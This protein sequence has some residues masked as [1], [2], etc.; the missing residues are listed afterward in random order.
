[1]TT[2]ETPP[3]D[4]GGQG[5]GK[6]K[7]F[8][9]RDVE[10]SIL[11]ESIQFIGR[12]GKLITENLIDYTRKN[13][14]GEFPDLKI[15]LQTWNQAKKKQV[16]IEELEAVGVFFETLREFY[17]FDENID[18]FVNFKCCL[19]SKNFNKATTC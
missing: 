1:M 2:Q 16:I 19:Q 5:E 14:L 17:K 6:K 11:N 18:D 8:Y 15:F 4:T 9:V 10:V 3:T 7:K 13:I 12:D